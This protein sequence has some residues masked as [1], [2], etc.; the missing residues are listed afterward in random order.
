MEERKAAPRS[1]VLVMATP[2]R[3][4]SVA[5]LAE[6]AGMQCAMISSTAELVARLRSQDS[7]RCASMIVALGTSK[8]DSCWPALAE[9]QAA[10]PHKQIFPIVLSRTAAQDVQT[11]LKCFDTGAKMVT[12]CLPAVGEALSKIAG[13][14]TSQGQFAC[15]VCAL[16]G[17]SEEALRTHMFLHHSTEPNPENIACPICGDPCEGRRPNLPVH[18]H[19]SH[20]DPATREPP[21]A[22]YPAFAWNVCRRRS[23][24]KF[25]LVNEPAG[26]SGGRPGYWLPA[27]RVDVGE[28]LE[29]AA[30]R[31]CR[32]EAGVESRV[33][34]VLRFMVDNMD[35]PRVMRV[36]MLSEPLDDNAEPKSIP[37]F[38]SCGA[39]W[40]AAEDLARLSDKDYRSPDPAELYPA[41]ASGAL[42]AQS[43]DGEA[44]QGL[45]ALMRRLTKGDQSAQGELPQ[46][47][48]VLKK[49]YPSSAFRSKS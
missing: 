42:R 9:L 37:N 36:V 38:E 5:A 34:G 23:D 25:L 7:E 47:W 19:N 8:E 1:L 21:H 14:L 46:V 6:A 20:G 4:S 26:I 49:A 24:G 16:P 22:P 28:S 15:P 44:F 35:A 12:D 41:V 29:E 18:L 13:C 39:L 43:V 48:E 45:E 40:T 11:R 3:M 31:E 33:V 27:G 17:L 32:E 30:V 10:P 2:Q